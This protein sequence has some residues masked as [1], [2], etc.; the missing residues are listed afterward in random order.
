MSILSET[1]IFSYC[2][3]FIIYAKRHL[4]KLAEKVY[5]FLQKHLIIMVIAWNFS[6]LFNGK[7]SSELNLIFMQCFPYSFSLPPFT[8]LISFLISSQTYLRIFLVVLWFHQQN[9]Q[10]SSIY[11]HFFF[12]ISTC[13][14]NKHL[15]LT[16][17]LIVIYPI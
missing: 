14:I 2:S 12:N 6:G 5:N 4:K 3:I 13:M 9:H 17:F 7:S 8:S 1:S 11:F 15:I 16:F 10:K